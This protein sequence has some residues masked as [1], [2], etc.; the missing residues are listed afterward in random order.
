M[1]VHKRIIWAEAD[2]VLEN[3]I[4]SAEK[5]KLLRRVVHDANVHGV[6][7]RQA[8]AVDFNIVGCSRKIL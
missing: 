4:V 8:W 5:D 1:G 6:E 7:L 3:D 2:G